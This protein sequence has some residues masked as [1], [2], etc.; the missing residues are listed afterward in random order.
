[1]LHGALLHMHGGRESGRRSPLR[2]GP[3]GALL[4]HLVNLLKG[5]A[6]GLRDKE[7]GVDKSAC[8]QTTPDKEN[9]RLHVAPLLADHVGSNDSD[10]GVPEPVG[11]GRE[12]NTARSDGKRENFTDDNPGTRTP[13]RGEEEDE[14]GDEGNL[15]V[16][17]RNVVRDRL[18]SIIGGWVGNFM[19]VVE[20]GS[21][22][23]DSD[24]ELADEHT[25]GA[26]EENSSATKPLDCPEGKRSGADVNESEN[27]GDEEDVLD[28]TGRLEEGS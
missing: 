23:N 2:R 15:G 8:A 5:Q 14:D 4:Q 7:V 17:S 1:M 13:G 28:G 24:D 27:E 6:L 10:D 21:D 16:D 26:I 20:T 12:T 11:G 3:R 22:T 9:R 18:K 25:K 19:G